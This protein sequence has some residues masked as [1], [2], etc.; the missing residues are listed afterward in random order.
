MIV[1]ITGVSSSPGYKTA[2]S[3]ANKYEVV[4]TYNEHSINIP[5]VT[6]VK[7]D[8]TRDSVRVINDYKPD[9]V[10]HMAAIGNVDQCEEQL[11]L[12]YR[13]NVVVSREL[14]T[15]AYRIG[16]AIYYLS[17]DYV[18]DGEKGLYTEDDIPRPVNYY[19]LTKLLAEEITKALNGSI[20]RVAWIYGTGP[21]RPN[22]GKTVVEK[23][24]RGEVVTAI[25]DQ[26]SSPT[27]NTII[28]EAFAR[29]LDIKFNG[30]IHVVGPRLSRYEFARA[31]ARYFGFSE[32]LIKPI[33]LI[34][35]NYRAK[36]PRDSS[37][38]NKKA[39]ELLGIPL[40]DINYALSIF[41]KELET[42]RAA[43]KP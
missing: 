32:E 41:K 30:V 7:A 2:I 3:L 33:R 37:L 24:M 35:V 4:G 8:L 25:T 40:N 39:I 13:V 21:G 16:S 26:W 1:L 15:A 12:C 14:L 27:L 29:L 6:T 28:G 9:V 23:L 17:T 38:S 31:I 20:V 18:F 5:G 11:E 22:F 34:D 19:G 43:V 42:E 36:R 10:I